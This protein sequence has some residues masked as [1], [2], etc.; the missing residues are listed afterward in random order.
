VQHS[1]KQHS[2]HSEILGLEPYEETL[3]IP[4]IFFILN[5]LKVIV[6]N[7]YKKPL[8]FFFLLIFLIL[9]R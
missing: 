7:I 5:I 1:F 9:D 4:S 2:V 8:F 6:N 3:R